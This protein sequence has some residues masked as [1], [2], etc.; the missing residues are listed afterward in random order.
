MSTTLEAELLQAA[1][2][3]EAECS[4]LC[5]PNCEPCT[6]ARRL[7][8]RAAW[9][10]ELQRQSREGGNL[11]TGDVGVL[12]S[13]LTGPIPSPGTAPTERKEP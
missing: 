11:W 2:F 5:R 10:R 3:Y 4:E 13:R 6:N 8:Q 7:R 12:L 9:V 1:D